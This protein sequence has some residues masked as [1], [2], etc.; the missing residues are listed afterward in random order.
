MIN[1]LSSNG[2][3]SFSKLW[4]LGTTNSGHE[5]TRSRGL[6][7]ARV[8]SRISG[9]I[10]IYI[11]IRWCRSLQGTVNKC[12]G[13]HC[14][15]S[16]MKSLMLLVWT[17]SCHSCC[18]IDNES[19]WLRLWESGENGNTTRKGSVDTDLR[20]NAAWINFI[21]FFTIEWP[22]RWHLEWANIRCKYTN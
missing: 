16:R 18:H 7:S 1:V 19:S 5:P 22:W 10:Y 21:K 11:Y 15:R 17:P 8:V 13:I 20:Q 12:A 4:R 6:R 3:G 14:S 2:K 9:Y